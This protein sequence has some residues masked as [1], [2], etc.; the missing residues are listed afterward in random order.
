MIRARSA[1]RSVAIAGAITLAAFGLCA[2]LAAKKDMFQAAAASCLAGIFSF[3]AT[4]ASGA[5]ALLGRNQCKQCGHR[6]RGTG[7]RSG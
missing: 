3:A 4:A 5:S 6:W 7:S 1:G 2:V